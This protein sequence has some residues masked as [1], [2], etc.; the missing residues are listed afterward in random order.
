MLQNEI[1]ICFNKTAAADIKGWH[2]LYIKLF[3]F[4]LEFLLRIDHCKH[5]TKTSNL[6]T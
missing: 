6:K 1:C 5:V 2:F 4:R 3:N